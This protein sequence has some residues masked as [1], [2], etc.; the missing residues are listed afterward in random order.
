MTNVRALAAQGALIAVVAAA[1]SGSAAAADG[2]APMPIA[3]DGCTMSENPAPPNMLTNNAQPPM[4]SGLG[5]VYTNE[6]DV[7][8]TEVDFRVH[9][10]GQT[11]KLVDRGL[12]AP[13]AKLSR[14]FNKFS[15]AFAG[16]SA[17]CSVTAAVFADGTHWNAADAAPS[18]AP[19]ASP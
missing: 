12:F 2:S 15:V 18:P 5:I 14:N 11:L 17:D 9:Y 8:A 10:N 16:S 6:R 3:V 7:A 1:I 13:H 4:A 19:V